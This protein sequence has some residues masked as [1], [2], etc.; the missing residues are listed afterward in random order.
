MEHVRYKPA[1]VWPVF[2]K[3]LNCLYLV[4]SWLHQHEQCYPPL[5]VVGSTFNRL[6]H[7]SH[8]W[9]C[10]I[11]L[12]LTTLTKQ[13][14]SSR[15]LPTVQARVAFFSLKLAHLTNWM[16]WSAKMLCPFIDSEER[17]RREIGRHVFAVIIFMPMYSLLPAESNQVPAHGGRK[18]NLS[19]LQRRLLHKEPSDLQ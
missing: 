9:L 5:P 19:C 6:R 15:C 10:W 14:E 8:Y 4:V 17:E 7:G 18:L 3:W 13:L 2:W 12:C 1:I 16:F 11:D